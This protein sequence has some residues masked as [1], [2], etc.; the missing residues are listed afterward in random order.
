M[1]MQFAFRA[2]TPGLTRQTALLAIARVVALAVAAAAAAALAG[3]SVNPPKP[4]RCDGSDRR[5]INSSI[6]AVAALLPPKSCS[7]STSSTLGSRDSG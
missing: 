1:N 7:G 2:I 3:C 6:P 4:P 5:V